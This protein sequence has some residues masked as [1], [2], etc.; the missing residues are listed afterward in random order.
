MSIIHGMLNANGWKARAEIVGL[1]GGITNGRRLTAEL[2]RQAA[3]YNRRRGTIST[4]KVAAWAE[5]CQSAP[6]MAAR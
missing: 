6:R 5:Y 4:K 1:P 2:W 3:D